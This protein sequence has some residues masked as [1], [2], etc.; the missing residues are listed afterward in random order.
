M[1]EFS[2]LRLFI[3]CLALTMAVPSMAS[4]WSVDPVQVQ[5]RG[6]FETAQILV[7]CK[8][9]VASNAKEKDLT[10]EATY[11][12]TDPNVF[13][14]ND[15]GQVRAIK[16]G[17]AELIVSVAGTS[18]KIQVVVEGIVD[19]PTV[20]FVNDVQP[21]LYRTGCNSGSCHASQY[22][23]GGFTLSV[24][25][26]DP[27]L[28]HAALSV[29]GR[30]R[31]ISLANPDLSLIL[32]KAT[33][34]IPHGGGERMKSRSNEYEM[35]KA[36]IAG[37]ASKPIATPNKV[38]KLIV[39]PSHVALAPESKQQFR[40]TAEYADGRKRD[41]SSLARFT[42]VDES[43]AQVSA[44]GLASTVG[45]GQG[46]ILARF[47][48]HAS[49]AT[50]VVPYSERI[51][52]EDWKSNNFVD[53]HAAAKFQEL[54]LSPSP[55]CDDATFLRRIFLDSIGTIPSL[56]DAEA[57]LAS[58]DPDKRSKWIDRLLGFSND[59][60]SGKYRDAY[61]AYWS[62]KWADLIRNNS[63]VVG[64]SGMWAFHNW[65]KESFREN[66][67]M[68]QF[69]K[70]LITAKGSIFSNGP[71][72]FY[73]I[74]NNPSDLAEST[75][76]LFLGT[77]LQCAKC[78]HHPY[79]KYS[80]SDYY[81]F[82]AHFARV[83][84]KGSTE[85]GMFG[86]ETIVMVRTNGEV[87]HPKTGVVM[88]PTPLFSDPVED[89]NDRRIPLANWITSQDNDLFARN[90]VNRYVAYLLGR[91]LV[92]P[93]DDLRSTNP[94]SNLALMNALV[95]DLRSNRFNVKHL[96]RTIMNSRLYQLDSQPTAANAS[97][98]RFYS[99]YFVKRL[100]AETLLDGMD[101][102]TGVPTKHPNLPLG[103]R[104][105]EL[106]DANTTNPLLIVFGKPKRASVCECERSPDENLA[107]ALHTLNGDILA[108]KL[109]DKQGRIAKLV[110]DNRTDEAKIA[111]LYLS[112]LSRR[113]TQE[114]I[115]TAKAVIASSPTPTEAYQDL[116]WA[117]IN[118]KQFLFIH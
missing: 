55:V 93:I 33:L 23:K 50:L 6:N 108:N 25:G 71:A 15:S 103:T 57:F 83:G 24:M 67:P 18:K 106:P 48:G 64:E 85:F 49:L 17:T 27:N 37:G 44:T 89:S 28:D 60:D 92:D 19:Q 81:G 10:S 45:R 110:A 72:N 46:A 63:A 21:V 51:A 94:P 100:S 99:H 54:G 87:T 56:E 14:V 52:L 65:L 3:V 95:D 62:L 9:D 101:L 113:P 59:A 16:N 96:M 2:L 34:S 66:K 73:R 111:E 36:W 69:V 80:Q 5:L 117:L 79:E 32:R 74:A 86:G 40:V 75:A 31:R 35:L 88:K 91:G 116:L 90:L 112:T 77:R 30:G 39:S 12:S 11:S 97:D 1:I 84:T 68:D 78:H 76:Q 70:E 109:A 42:S 104:A 8:S 4:E 13:A 61:A 114:E 38:T 98:T 58:V 26:F 22:G 107:Q 118:S 115:D 102:A 47:S 43:V 20:D 7:S 29:Q 82:A 105:I 41:V 53:D